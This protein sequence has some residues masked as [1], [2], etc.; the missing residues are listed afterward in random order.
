MIQLT[1]LGRAM[2]PQLE[3]MLDAADAASALSY[4]KLTRSRVS[5]KIGLGPGVSAVDVAGAV[6]EVT[7]M[8]PE[9]TIH[10]EESGPAALIEAMLT[11][12]IDCALLPDHCDI[13]ERLNCWPLYADR[14]VVVLPTNHKLMAKAAVT[15]ED[16]VDETVLLG[17]HCGD[18]VDRL[19]AITSYSL[20]LQ[21]YH[22]STSQILDLIAE[23]LGIAL[24]SDRFPLSPQLGVRPLYEPEI[25]R[26]IL[27]T[28]VA[29]RPLN[30][31]AG[32]FVKL[33]RTQT[34]S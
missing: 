23:G 4:A 28:V 26:R 2:R 12:I 33:C 9:V 20:H 32:S 5:L 14:A 1:E 19:S 7:K 21:R 3:A 27:L 31:A 18:F 25:S 30:P 11:D 15:A 6:R 24:L 8:L 16:I 13:P 34:F 10:F 17:D 22:G 29:G